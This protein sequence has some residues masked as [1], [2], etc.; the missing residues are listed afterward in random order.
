MNREIVKQSLMR[1]IVRDS[2]I[3]FNLCVSF[4]FVAV[5]QLHSNTQVLYVS[6]RV[7]LLRREAESMY[8]RIAIT[9]IVIAKSWQ[10]HF[11]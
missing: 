8:L 9:Y 6:H 1:M 10:V 4:S 7:L 3:Y 5:F 2:I 11:H